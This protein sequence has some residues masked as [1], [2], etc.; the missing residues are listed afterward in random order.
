MEKTE[1]EEVN[2]AF[3]K[4]GNKNAHCLKHITC[5]IF[6]MGVVGFNNNLF[7]KKQQAY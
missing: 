2:Q 3:Y 7:P 1:K 5:N 6:F 4:K